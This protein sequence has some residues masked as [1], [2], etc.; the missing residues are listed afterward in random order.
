MRFAQN[1]LYIEQYVK[2]ANC[3]VLI[4]EKVSKDHVQHE[5]ETYCSSWCVDWKTARDA[6]R[7]KKKGEAA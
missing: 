2:C 3:G 6:R 1:G 4:Y 7:A 5:G